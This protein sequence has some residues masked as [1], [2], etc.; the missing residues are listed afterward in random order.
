MSEDLVLLFDSKT[1]VYHLIYHLDNKDILF[2]LDE[3]PTETNIIY[4]LTAD[5]KEEQRIYNLIEK[6]HI[7]Q[8]IK[9]I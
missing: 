8:P 1:A 9:Y 7:K 2:S 3:I 4:E 6:Y 5:K